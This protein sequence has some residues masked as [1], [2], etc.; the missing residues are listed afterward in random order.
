MS[1]L[2]VAPQ[3]WQ[4]CLQLLRGYEASLGAHPAGDRAAEGGL[5]LAEMPLRRS[6]VG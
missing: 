6:A 4:S 1:C 3:V 2:Y 5:L